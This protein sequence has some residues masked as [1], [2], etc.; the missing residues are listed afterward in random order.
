LQNDSGSGGGGFSFSVGSA[1]TAVGYETLQANTSGSDNTAIG[2]LALY[3]NVTGYNNTAVGVWSLLNNNGGYNN[4][5]SGDYSLGANTSGSQNTAT[6]ESALGG[7]TTASFNTATGAGA[8]AAATGGGNTASG[9]NALCSLTTGYNNVAAGYQALLTNTVGYDNVA[10]GVAS[11]Q[12]DLQG[13]Q[14]TAVGTYTFQNLTSG[15]G[16]VGLGYYAGNSLTSGDNNIYIGNPGAATESNVIRIGNGQSTTYIAGTVQH[17]VCSSITI[18]GGA[19]LAEPFSIT[20]PG[21]SVSAGEVV[22]IDDAHPGQLKL[23]D[24]P[25]DTRVAGVVSGANGINPGIQMHQEVLLDGSRNVA[26]TGRVYVQA[27]ASNGAIKPGDLLTTSSIPGCAMRVSNHARAQ[28]A[29]LGK[30]MTA[31]KGGRGMVL[32]LVTLQ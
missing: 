26:L 17:L 3:G 24:Q 5:A 30:A 8:M 22:V 18:S 29:I 23:T 13:H 20:A 16:N 11:F 32:V 19:D 14:D 7:N 10:I 15:S 6:G 2:Y 28:G 25:Y 1:N 4:T 21:Q 27:D 9:A 31:L 12:T